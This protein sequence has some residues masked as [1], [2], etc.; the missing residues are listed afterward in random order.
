MHEVVWPSSHSNHQLIVS[1]VLIV[2]TTFILRLCWRTTCADALRLLR[3][4]SPPTVSFP[5]DELQI[6]GGGAGNRIVGPKNE[7]GVASELLFTPLRLRGLTLR[8]RVI[9]AAAFEAGCD[10]RGAPLPS[11]IEHHREVAAGGAALTTVAYAAVSADGRSFASQLLLTSDGVAREGLRELVQA[12]HSEG[13]AV[14]VQLTHAGSFAKPQLGGVDGCQIAPSAIFN[15]AAFNWAREMSTADMRRVAS[16]FATAAALAVECGVDA[17]EVHLGHGYLLS[18]FLSPYSNRRSDEY[19]GQIGNR[20]RFPLQVL[21]SV[22]GAVDS[23]VPILVKFNLGDGFVG[24]Q[25]LPDAIEV[26]KT[27]YEQGLVDLLIPSGGWITRNGL[28][29]LR[30]DVPL[31]EMVWAQPLATLRWSLRLF[32]RMY[33][34][35]LPWKPHF[36]EDAASELL[37]SLPHGA[38]VCL[39]G[40]VNSKSGMEAALHRGF[41]AVSVARMLL[42]E[43]G[44]VHRMQRDRGL[45]QLA[46]SDRAKQGSNPRGATSEADVVSKCSHCNLCIVE[47]AM[48]ERPVRCIERDIEDLAQ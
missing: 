8:N 15:P 34:P 31:R 43:P 40:G 14:A 38:N 19:G 18:Q 22:R 1:L 5:E 30:G 2:A 17:I 13:G 29:M 48:A 3:D 7:A 24:G 36:F 12:V 4:L 32:G 11:L 23:Q 35:S 33:V 47:S 9:K 37:C 26:A 16:D 45:D 28:F 41:K 39:L 44:I 10:K 25:T 21:R 42:R 6:C 27:M 46:S 20:M